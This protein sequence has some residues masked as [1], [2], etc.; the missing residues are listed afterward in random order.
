MEGQKEH[1]YS[2]V[3]VRGS[4]QQGHLL[5][6]GVNTEDVASRGLVSGMPVLLPA[7]QYSAEIPEL[8]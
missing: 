8:I 1:M 3:V 4:T 5:W 6:V 7:L 2:M